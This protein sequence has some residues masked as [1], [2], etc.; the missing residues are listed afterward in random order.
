MYGGRRQPSGQNTDCRVI[1][2]GSTNGENLAKLRG[3]RFGTE[4][5]ITDESEV[6]MFLGFGRPFLEIPFGHLQLT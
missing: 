1:K 3:T 6:P 5:V 4:D 2:R